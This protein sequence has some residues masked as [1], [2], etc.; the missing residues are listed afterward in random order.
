MRSRILSAAVAG[1]AVAAG[2]A[3]P[4]SA[5]PGVSSAMSC[6]SQTDAAGIDAMLV[7][8]GS[9]LAGE[10]ATFVTQGLG[11]GLDPRALL[12]IA[13]HETILETYVPSQAI[14]N[15]F[16]LG[17]G[18][19][20]ASDADAIARAARTLGAY[21]LP[22]GRTTLATIG[23]KWAP[24]GV[25]NDPAG[26]NANWTTGVGTY[27]AAL[28]GDP[29]RPVLVASQGASPACLGAPSLSPEPAQAAPSGPPVVTAWGGAVPQVTGSTPGGGSDPASGEP[30]VVAGFVF[31]LA[32]PTDAPAAYRDAFAEPGAS[33]CEGGRRQC[34]VTI[35]SAPGH[36]AV[37]MA[38][39]TLRA[40]G[41]AEAE[42]GIAFWIE[43]PGGDRLGYGPL[44]TY[45]EG[46]GEGTV[47]AVGRPLG[48]VAG[49]VRIAWERVGRRINPF[50]LLAAT[51]PPRD[52]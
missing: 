42:G 9:P 14:H 36:A 12:A 33:D 26:L 32:L 40:S 1:A 23:A 22:E 46:V 28:G 5:Q 51:R 41:P 11:V 19:A 3:A 18:L 6:I 37:A 44:A 43:T 31:P 35:A 52:A 30:A 15:P 45:S 39:G 50:P 10:G 25:A 38:A 20:F 16:G 49:W 21:Y 27:Y 17:P 29:G 48:S 24:I 8:A 47:V 13:A 4:A 7:R 34:A 2:V